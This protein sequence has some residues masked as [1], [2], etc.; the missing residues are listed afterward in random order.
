ML[1]LQTD[2]AWLHGWRNRLLLIILCYPLFFFGLGDRDLWSSHE[3]RAAQNAQGI[4]DG[5]DW[6]LPR[7]YDGRIEM[8]KPPLYYWAAA[9]AGKLAGGLT[10]FLVR[11]PAA[12]AGLFTV[13]AVHEL[14]RRRGRPRAALLAAVI[15]ATMVRFTWISRVARIDMP[16]T[17]SVFIA[18]AAFYLGCQARLQERW[19]TCRGWWATGYFFLAVSVLFKGPIG[20]ILM[21]AGASVYLLYERRHLRAVLA[22]LLWG[23]PLILAVVGPWFWIANEAT[24]GVFAK[25]FL[26][27]HNF[28]RGLGGDEQL[29][30]HV[31]PPWH[32]LGLLWIDTLPWSLLLPWA[33]WRCWRSRAWRVDVEVAFGGLW[34]LGMFVFLSCMKYKRPEYLLPAYP[35]LAIFLGVM[36]ERQ[37]QTFSLRRW[38][39]V[40]AGIVGV[41]LAMAAGWMAYTTWIVPRMEPTRELR[42]FAQAVRQRVPPHS[43]ILIFRIDSHAL[44]YHLGKPVELLWQWEN[45]DIW[46]CQPA[47][48]Y[49]IMP[50][51][52]A[53]QWPRFMEAGQLY[54][55]LTMEEVCG[56]PR[57]EKLVLFCTQPP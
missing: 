55:V 46:A 37:L 48:L 3:A 42:S 10:P 15:L 40:F 5:G 44:A 13:L 17:L 56:V 51:Q 22:S 34:F 41:V 32:Y 7:L 35:G 8:Q 52:W 4:L 19:W 50:Q 45:L 9:A 16:L 49:V 36:L 21:A 54:P 1:T 23:L 26:W 57:E 6:K 14:L 28:Q 27:R 24:Q 18:M 43:M 39:W 11:L 25:E 47:K 31:H 20:I 53:D 30:S 29:D 12:L 38:R 33:A 2:P